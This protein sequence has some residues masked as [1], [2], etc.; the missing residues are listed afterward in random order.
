MS[1]AGL[2]GGHKAAVPH[3]RLLRHG[4]VKLVRTKWLE[5]IGWLGP[6][7]LFGL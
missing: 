6:V 4:E 3:G 2:L 5:P 7:S 1:H